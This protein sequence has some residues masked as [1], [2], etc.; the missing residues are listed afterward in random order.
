VLRS[1]EFRD[2]AFPIYCNVDAKPVRDAA[3]VR[4]ALERQ[5]AGAVRWQD[6]IERM[7]GDEGVR[8]FVEFG[9]KPTLARMVTQIANHL[10]IEGVE[11]EAVCTPDDVRRVGAA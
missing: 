5:F 1:V 10:G 11:S 9:P 3:A 4:D 6:S 8:R 2:P 7:L